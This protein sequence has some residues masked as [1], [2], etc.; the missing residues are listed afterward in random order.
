[1]T[2]PAQISLQNGIDTV[3]DRPYSFKTRRRT[4][5]HSYLKFAA[6]IATSAAVMLGLMYLNTWQLDHVFWSETRFYATLYMAAAMGIIMG[7]TCSACTRTEPSISA[8]LQA[9]PAVRRCSVPGAQPGDGGGC[10]VHE[11][12]DPASLDCRAH[13]QQGPYLRSA[14]AQAG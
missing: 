12:H 4:M 11:G 10:R 14:H 6:M 3:A 7:L 8:S 1:M 5:A 13:E 2:A 9:V